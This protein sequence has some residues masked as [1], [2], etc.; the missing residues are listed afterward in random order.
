VVDGWD[1]FSAALTAPHVKSG[2]A[3]RAFLDMY[4]WASV[5]SRIEWP[6]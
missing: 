4:S 3:S 2:N 6:A 1:A 5:V